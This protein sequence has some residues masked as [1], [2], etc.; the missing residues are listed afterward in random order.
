MLQYY[1]YTLIYVEIVLQPLYFAPLCF[2]NVLF[3]KLI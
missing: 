3:F 2:V 1:Y